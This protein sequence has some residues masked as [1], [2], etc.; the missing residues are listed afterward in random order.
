MKAH[1]GTAL[2]YAGDAQITLQDEFLS[3]TPD[4]LLVVGSGHNNTREAIVLECKS[5][6]P[7]AHLPD[8]KPEHVFQAQVQMGLFNKLTP[9]KP[10]RAIISY[11]NS[12]FWNEV[13]EFPITFDPDVFAVAQSRAAC[14]MQATSASEMKPEG[15]IAGGGECEYCPFV[16]ACG[17]IRRGPTIADVTP[18]D[19]PQFVAEVADLARQ[20]EYARQ[21]VKLAEKQV[22]ECQDA[23]KTRLNDKRRVA[24]TATASALFGR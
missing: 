9:Y 2:K 11:T 24:S 19:D 17:K 20:Y 14:I 12:S 15:W 13:T 7:R 18:V 1:Y 16:R 6:D 23:I 3:A 21:S 8:A 22:R 5:I 10:Q 4:A